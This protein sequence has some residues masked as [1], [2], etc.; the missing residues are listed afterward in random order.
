MRPPLLSGR[1]DK[2]PH[3]LLILGE[4]TLVLLE[5]S[6]PGHDMDINPIRLFFEG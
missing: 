6:I 5:P 3:M 4:W 2:Y 1:D